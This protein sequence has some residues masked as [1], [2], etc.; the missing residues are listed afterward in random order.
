[1]AAPSDAIRNGIR[2]QATL[3]PGELAE[4]DAFA[5]RLT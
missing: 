1:M 5:A 3:L 4:A 2:V